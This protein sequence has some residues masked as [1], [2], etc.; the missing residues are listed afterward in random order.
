LLKEEEKT[1]QQHPK[2]KEK[3]KKSPFEI[4]VLESGSLYVPKIKIFQN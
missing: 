3:K 4:D 2:K 1:N